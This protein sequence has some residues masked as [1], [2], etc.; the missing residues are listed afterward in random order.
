MTI[1]VGKDA[2]G[3]H[4]ERVSRRSSERERRSTRS[5]LL[6][7]NMIL[8]SRQAQEAQQVAAK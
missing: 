2:F 7:Q 4:F 8:S 6:V 1:A 3:E 5:I